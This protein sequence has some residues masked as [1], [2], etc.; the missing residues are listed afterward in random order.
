L[1]TE[2]VEST[3]FG[4]IKGAFTGAVNNQD[5]AFHEADSGTLLLDEITEIDINTQAKLLR[6]LQ[7]KEFKKVGSQETRKV[8]VRI[9]ATTNRDVSKAINE[10]NFR[11]DLYFRLNVFPIQVPSLKER[12]KDIPKLVEYFCQKYSHEYGLPEKSV[13]AQLLDYL[14]NKEWSGNVRE[15]EN[16][17]QRG[18]IMSNNEEVIKKEHTENP[19]FQNLDP[20]FAKDKVGEIPILPIEEMEL[21]L[22]KKALE[23]TNG[24]QKEASKLLKISDRTI[25]NKL[26]N[27]DFPDG[28]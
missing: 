18:V 12:K 22:I 28:S 20:L 14:K 16:Y 25:R 13:S 7:E 4:H 17:V 21:I 27:I 3:L 9:I 8:D 1:P 11:S 2:L 5:G 10:G 26:K 6:V 19:L 23:R 15:L 24:N